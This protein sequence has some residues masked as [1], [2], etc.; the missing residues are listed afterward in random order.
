VKQRIIVGVVGLLILLPSVIWGGV[1]AIDVIVTL[2]LA[3]A[4]VEFC[5]MAIP[6]RRTLGYGVF[7]A[8]VA[9]VHVVNLYWPE[10][11]TSALSLGALLCLIT[12]L[13][14]VPDTNRGARAGAWMVMGLVYLPILF[15]M[16]SAL[17]RLEHGVVWV[18]VSLALAW[19]ADTGA[20]FAG[21]AFGKTPLFPRVSP[22]KTWE[23]AIGGAV[24]VV[25]TLGVVKWIWLPHMAWGHVVAL[26]LLGDVAGVIGDLVESAFKRA[27]DV[28]DSG[29]ILPGHGGILDRVDSLLFTAPV[30]WLYVT[31]AGLG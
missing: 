2:A 19:A 10:Q 1:I 12:G 25:L 11:V 27:S 3:V 9:L 14:G 31:T 24:S 30:T 29:S 22:K 26:G 17:R 5:G 8:S 18:F 6:D 28:K 7:G 15:G 21:R 23:G 20:Y 4:V 16:L 13:L